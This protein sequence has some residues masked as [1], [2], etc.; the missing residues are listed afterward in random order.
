MAEPLATPELYAE[1]DFDRIYEEHFSFVWR[2]LRYLGIPPAS[3][4]DAAQ[5]VFVVV[6]RRLDEFAGRSSVRTWL[7]GIA[8]MVA[9]ALLRRERKKGGHQPLSLELPS[10]IEGPDARFET[11]EAVR[12]LDA[13]LA[14]LD[15]DKRA[16]FVLA[17]LEQMTAPEISEAL[18]VKLNTVYSRLRHARQALEQALAQRGGA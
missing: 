16:V 12:W 7:F 2:S 9:L 5:D 8:H 4:D 13:F 6:H 14:T 18:G 15:D 1:L 17:E 3:L 10:P 11:A